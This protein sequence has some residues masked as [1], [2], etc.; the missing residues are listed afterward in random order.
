M[1]IELGGTFPYNEENLRTS[2]TLK[3]ID[4]LKEV[5]MLYYAG[6]KKWMHELGAAMDECRWY[7]KEYYGSA[8]QWLIKL[9]SLMREE[10]VNG[11]FE[12]DLVWN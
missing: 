9:P 10:N 3:N 2:W 4:R 6:N 1:V 11:L 7:D 5:K 12:G 8:C